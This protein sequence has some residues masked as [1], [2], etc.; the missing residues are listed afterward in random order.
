MMAK[1]LVKMSHLLCVVATLTSVQSAV[2]INGD[3][4]MQSKAL[5]RRQAMLAEAT[6]QL[7]VDLV[8]EQANMEMRTLFSDDIDYFLLADGK[9]GCLPD[10][11]P[12]AIWQSAM[13]KRAAELINVS[14]IAADC[15]AEK[16][17]AATFEIDA[18]FYDAHPAGCFVASCDPKIDPKGLCAFLNPLGTVPKC[19]PGDST[20]TPVIAPD[21]CGGASICP[22]KRFLYGGDD[23]AAADGNCTAGYVVLKN[24]GV[25]G[26]AA[27]LLSHCKG[28]PFVTG[29]HNLSKIMDY[30]VGCFRD[31]EPSAGNVT[32]DCL[33]Y[34]PGNTDLGPGTSVKGTPICIVKEVTKLSMGGVHAGGTTTR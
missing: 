12:G 21:S 26:T 22:R 28:D 5:M 24:E 30:P 29:V 32:H 20:V 18:A 15:P 33:Y 31:N 9:G 4:S 3:G 13:C 25:C 6:P 23:V 19:G 16:C 7:S 34:N 8:K 2:M 1:H 27:S 10:L 17:G 14:T 11:L